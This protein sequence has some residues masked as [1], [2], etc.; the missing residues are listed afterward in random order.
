MHC[1]L[2]FDY[3]CTCRC[4]EAIDGAWGRNKPMTEEYFFAKLNDFE[5]IYM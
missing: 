2:E 1:E 3:D 5:W 4:H